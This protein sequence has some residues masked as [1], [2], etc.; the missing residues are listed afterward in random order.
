MSLKQKTIHGLTWSFID[1]FAQKGITFVIG[2]ILAR[3]LS[4]SEFG[5]IGMI[6]I[7]VA[8]S[9]SFINSGFGSALI[10]KKDC[11]DTDLSTVFYYNLVVGVLF[12]LILLV[13]APV[14]SRFFNEPQLKSLVQVLAI[15]LVIDFLTLI[16]TT[17]LTKRVDFK[18]QTKI[19]VISSIFSGIIGIT[20]AFKG[21]GVWSLVV[22]QL[23]QHLANSVLL[24]LLNRWRPLFVFSKQSFKELFSFGYKLMISG[25]INAIYRNVY[26]MIIGKYFSAQELGYYTRANNFKNLPSSN[27]NGIISR[28]SY[29]VLAQ[30]QG[31]KVY[32][33]EENPIFRDYTDL[34]IKLF[35]IQKELN[36]THLLNEN[37]SIDDKLKNR[38]IIKNLFNSNREKANVLNAYKAFNINI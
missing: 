19:S 32:L 13:S 12:F 14:I 36:N 6:T 11:T 37:L 30:L 34:G 23:S 7:F 28:V 33:R 17:I 9:S 4:P 29:P 10:R 22:K 38:K 31:S 35:S 25:L 15:I 16:Q 2:I 1:N 8:I 3:L 27:I 24:W 20:M 18:L 21:F 26:Y 5:L